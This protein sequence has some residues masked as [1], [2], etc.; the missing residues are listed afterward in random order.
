M[1]DNTLTLGFNSCIITEQLA[2]RTG[3]DRTEVYG[4]QGLGNEKKKH[5]VTFIKKY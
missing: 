5:F 3:I 1:K 4:R 2:G